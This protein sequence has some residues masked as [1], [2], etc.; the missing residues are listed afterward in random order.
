MYDSTVTRGAARKK[1]IYKANL[2]TFPLPIDEA[3]GEPPPPRAT[4]LYIV[5]QY[6]CNPLAIRAFAR[7]RESRACHDRMSV[8][9]RTRCDAGRG[10]ALL[11]LQPVQG[12]DGVFQF[13]VEEGAA[14]PLH[15]VHWSCDSF[16]KERVRLC[17]TTI[18]AELVTTG[19]TNDLASSDSAQW[20]RTRTR[21]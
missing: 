1:I 9:R 10:P 11:R 21:R 13:A 20:N 16:S 18:P 2:W 12:Q 6:S 15:G 17:P 8:Q 19:A 7:D 4:L 5:L 3:R 14:M